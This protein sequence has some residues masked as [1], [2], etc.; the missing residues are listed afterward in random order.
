MI[1]LVDRKEL[2]DL[3]KIRLKEAAALLQLG[4]FDGAFY[5]A[6]YAVGCGLKA[7]IAKGTRR[8][9]FPDKKKVESS[10][11]HNLL[12]LI[13]VA[14]LD[15]KCSLHAGRNPAFR[16]NW[17]YVQTWSEQSRYRRH[18]PESARA[19]LAAVSDRR[20]GVITWIRQQW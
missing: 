17:D 7:C 12:Q 18:R 4:L 11:T 14:G 2:Q 19:L 15:E 5:L 8:G 6:G 16:S 13:K 3:A 1:S 10:H 20:H 9:E